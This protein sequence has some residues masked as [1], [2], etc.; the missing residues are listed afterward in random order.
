MRTIIALALLLLSAQVALAER[1]ELGVFAGYNEPFD[2][3]DASDDLLAGARARFPF[4]TWVKI[5][6]AITWYDM[7]RE[8]YRARSVPQEVGKWQ[9]VSGMA[10][11]TLGR[12][13]GERGY[14][15][16]V[17]A[18]VGYYVLRKDESP[19]QERFGLNAGVGLMVL[20]SPNISLDASGRAERISL[21]S[22]GSRGLV[23]LR[24]GIHYHIGD[25]R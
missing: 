11:V 13:F 3:A 2:Q 14:H 1:I 6:P 20:M 8:P 19:D 7:D 5:E 12:D 16:Y 4:G 21:E 22:G 24:L 23:N 15:P 10:N 25:N 18:G 17:T 9:I